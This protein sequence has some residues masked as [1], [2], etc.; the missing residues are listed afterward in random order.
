MLD[1]VKEILAQYVE[2]DPAEINESTLL[3]EDL[4]LTSFA[5]MTMMGDFEEAFD[6][7]LDDES[8]LNGIRTVGDVIEFLKKKTGE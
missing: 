3:A 6:I 1:K 2:V 5:F 8:E 7:T 4:G